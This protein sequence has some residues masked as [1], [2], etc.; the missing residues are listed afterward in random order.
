MKWVPRSRS[1]KR[2]DTLLHY[3][4]LIHHA[5]LIFF[6]GIY[7]VFSFRDILLRLLPKDKPTRLRAQRLSKA[8]RE[9]EAKEVFVLKKSINS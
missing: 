4:A 9:Q 7:T 8:L 2:I 1:K 3:T 6:K 5:L